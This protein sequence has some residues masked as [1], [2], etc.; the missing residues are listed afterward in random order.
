VL[1]KHS[2]KK[3]L[4]K[5][6]KSKEILGKKTKNQHY[7]RGPISCP[8]FLAEPKIIALLSQISAKASRSQS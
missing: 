2:Q 1:K 8:V 7:N 5:K 6:L 3:I 4:D